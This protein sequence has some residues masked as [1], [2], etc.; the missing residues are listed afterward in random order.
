MWLTFLG[1]GVFDN[2]PQWIA[3]AI[4]RAVRRA[5]DASLDIRV[6]HYRRVDATMRARIDAGLRAAGL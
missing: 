5:G 3:D 4:A 2:D 1:G 6:A